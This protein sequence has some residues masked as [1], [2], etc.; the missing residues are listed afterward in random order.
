MTDTEIAERLE[1]S[2]LQ[3][4]VWLQLL[5]DEGILEKKNKPVRYFIKEPGFFE[6]GHH[7]T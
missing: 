5:V 7:A 4:R 3:T 2:T 6:N 1:L